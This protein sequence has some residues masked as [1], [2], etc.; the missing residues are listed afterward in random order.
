MTT[1]DGR[2]EGILISLDVKGAFDRV[3]WSRLKARLRAKGMRGKALKLLHD[4]FFERFIQV[5]N[6]GDKSKLR[7]IFSGVPQG[8]IWSPGLWDFDIS[9]MESFLSVL[10]MLICYAD[11][12]S[13]WYK[14]TEEN[15]LTIIAQINKDLESLMDWARDNNT[16]FEPSK[17]HFTLISLRTS[18]KFDLCFPFPRPMFD[19]IPIKREESV[20]LVGFTFEKEMSWAKMISANAKKARCR[21][22]MLCKLRHMLDDESMKNMYI[23]FIRPMLEYGSVQY[24]GAKASHLKKLDV[25]QRVAERIGNFEVPSLRLGREAA[26]I[27]L[28][29]KLLDGAGRGVLANYAPT[30]ITKSSNRDFVPGSRHVTRHLQLSDRSKVGSLDIFK[31]SY[32]GCIHKIWERL[33]MHLLTK[34]HQHGWRKIT[35]QCKD[36]ITSKTHSK[37]KL[38]EG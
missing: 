3:W 10:A 18:H 14:I 4:Y 15:R 29:L 28:T 21:I 8:A 35:K 12:C 6:N 9:E 30:L 31:D 33:P 19:G 22:G 11:D 17:T 38:I 32:L 1:L 37:S 16:T 27:S 2:G 25:V 34:G 26:A 5:V 23:S 36:H 24:M 7:E 20:K 13:L